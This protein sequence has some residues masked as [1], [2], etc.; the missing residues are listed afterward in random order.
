M[1]WRV[2][3][4]V[5]AKPQGYVWEVTE[6]PSDAVAKTTVAAA[7]RRGFFKFTDPENHYWGGPAAANELI[8]A[9]L[10]RLVG[11]DAADVIPASIEG[12]LGV[13]SVVRPAANLIAWRDVP[14]RVHRDVERQVAHANQFGVMLAFDA[15][16]LNIDRASGKN[17]IAYQR[18]KEAAWRVY[19]IDHGHTLHGNYDRW[20]WGGHYRSPFWDDL[21]RYYDLPQGVRSYLT[22]YRQVEPYVSRI[23]RIKPK[24]IQRLVQLVPRELLAPEEARL[25]EELLLWRQARLPFI[26]RRWFERRVHAR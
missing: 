23:Q 4:K 26:L 15:W 3:R 21:W 9:G 11:L 6:E 19:F 8:A 17:V 10:A 2:V 13:V 22:S 25:I 24:A 16:V 1:N 12:H 5:S 7:P 20:R 14:A 18:A